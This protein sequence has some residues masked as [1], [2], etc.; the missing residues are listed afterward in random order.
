MHAL[1]SHFANL[2]RVITCEDV[3]VYINVTTR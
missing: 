3:D 1:D 2:E